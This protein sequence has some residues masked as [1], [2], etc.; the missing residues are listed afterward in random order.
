M[1]GLGGSPAATAGAGCCL[2]VKEYLEEVVGPSLI[3]KN[4]FD[5]ERFAWGGAT[6]IGRC[7]WAGADAALFDL[8]GKLTG[9]PVYDLL[10]VDAE[11]N[12]RLRV[13]ASAGVKYA[14]YDRPGQ[15]V[16]EAAAM[17]DQ[18]FTAYKFRPGTE[19]E[20]S[21][22]DG[23]QVHPLARARARRGRGTASTSPSSCAPGRW[24]RAPA[25]SSR[26]SRSCA[27]PGS[28]SRWTGGGEGRL[29][30]LPAAA[31]GAADGDDLRGASPCWG[32]PR[33]QGVGPTAGAIEMP[34]PDAGRNRPDGKPGGVVRMAR[35]ARQGVS[36]PHNWGDG[37]LHPRQRRPSWAASPNALMLEQF[38]TWGPAAHRDLHRSAGGG[39]RV[40][41]TCRTGPASGMELA[42]GSREA[43][44]LQAGGVQR[45]PE[46][47]DLRVTK[48]P[49]AVGGQQSLSPPQSRSPDAHTPKLQEPQFK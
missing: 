5:L 38:E 34:Q 39:G 46:S 15:L 6:S 14:W 33:A 30:P 9:R 45:A 4:P 28:R 27:S 18:G 17:K 49:A 26:F 41:G 21:G 3:G 32:Q 23:R 31:G 43:V 1:T 29:R 7:A 24:R 42:P 8:I 44:S 16:E 25:A 36:A 12:T 48:D 2:P 47:G 22:N 13:Y 40:H 37:Q 20:F 10:A 11:P 35:L 19:W